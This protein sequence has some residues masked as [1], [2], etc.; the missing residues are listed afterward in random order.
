MSFWEYLGSRRERLVF[1][2]WQHASMVFQTV[3]VA[4]VL[5]VL[6]GV[7]VYRSARLS[8]FATSAAGV[9]FTVPSLALLGLLI[10]PLGLGVAPS[11]VALTLYSLLP[12]VRNTVVGLAGVDRTLVDAAR[13]IGMTR[14]AILL[15]IELPL[16]WP[17]IL[18]GARVSTQ[19]A[20]GIGAIAAYVNGPGLGEQIFSGLARLGGANAINMTLAGT[21]GIVLLALL[22]DG[23]FVLIGRLTTP[24]GIRV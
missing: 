6:I 24:R 22:F 7:A 16:A 3:L 8:A 21:L 12:I 18:T 20:M 10:T 17:V 23:C 9:F 15:R 14:A 5:G 19:L 4:L 1:E 11:V 13:G 2:T